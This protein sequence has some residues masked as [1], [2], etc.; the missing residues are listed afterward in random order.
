MLMYGIG[1]VNRPCTSVARFTPSYRD[2]NQV[3]TPDIDTLNTP[4]I[5]KEGGYHRMAPLLSFNVL[6]NSRKTP[7]HV[8]RKSVRVNGYDHVN[9]LFLLGGL[10]SP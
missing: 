4:R 5:E 10:K 1:K 6:L 8:P 3:F 9:P 7:L 2:G